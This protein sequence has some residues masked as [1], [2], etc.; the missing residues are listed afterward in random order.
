MKNLNYE[1]ILEELQEMNKIIVNDLTIQE[2]KEL[3][4]KLH[5]D[6]IITIFETSDREY[7]VIV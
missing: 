6:G 4:N 1:K 5:A 7:L 2:I 3:Q